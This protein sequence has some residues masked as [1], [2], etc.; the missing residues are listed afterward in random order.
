MPTV[1]AVVNCQAVRASVRANVRASVRASVRT[2]D[3]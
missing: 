2:V 3:L 1:V